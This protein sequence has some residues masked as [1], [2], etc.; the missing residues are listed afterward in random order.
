MV[1]RHSPP[2]VSYKRLAP[3]K[4]CNKWDDS[5]N[6][7]A[8]NQLHCGPTADRPY[9]Y[10]PLG[11]Y[12]PPEGIPPWARPAEGLQLDWLIAVTL[13]QSANCIADLRRG[14]HTEGCFGRTI[15]YTTKS[16]KGLQPNS[17]LNMFK[18]SLNQW[19]QAIFEP[20]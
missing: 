2:E 16:R 14:E 11:E 6:V 17:T 4:V 18:N 8:I 3:P 9:E 13:L 7:T 19:Y 15:I 20:S 10:A 12:R 1:K 5:S